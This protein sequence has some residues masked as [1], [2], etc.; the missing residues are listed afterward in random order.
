MRPD[1]INWQNTTEMVSLE[2]KPRETVR[3]R[4]L[5]SLYFIVLFQV[6]TALVLIGVFEIFGNPFFEDNEGREHL[7][8]LA[9]AVGAVSSQGK[10]DSVNQILKSYSTFDEVGFVAIRDNKTNKHLYVHTPNADAWVAY[11]QK[12]AKNVVA[13]EGGFDG[14]LKLLRQD[15]ARVHE[16]SIPT[17]WIMSWKTMQRK[18]NPPA[19]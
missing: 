16:I 7:K 10:I 5:R 4:L 8:P 17:R 6:V 11:Q 2:L 19:P 14:W 9:A 3:R 15:T 1:A 13:N 12:H 18:K